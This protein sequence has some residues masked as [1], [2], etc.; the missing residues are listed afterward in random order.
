[1]EIPL[2]NIIWSIECVEKSDFGQLT[3]NLS[4]DTE[5]PL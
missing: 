4:N 5:N 2:V 1:M 3:T